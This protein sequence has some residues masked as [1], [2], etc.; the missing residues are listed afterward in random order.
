MIKY[1]TNLKFNKEGVII[2]FKKREISVL[3]LLLCVVCSCIVLDNNACAEEKIFKFRL[4][5][6]LPASSLNHKAAEHFAELVANKTNNRVEIEIYP[7]SQL[8]SEKD[9]ADAVAM[10]VLDFALLGMGEIDKRYKPT[11]VIDGPFVFRDREHQVKFFNSNLYKQ[12]CDEMAETINIRPISSFY[13]GTRY[14]TCNTIIKNPDDLKGKKIRCPDQPIFMATVRAMGAAPTPMAISEVYLAL[15]Q[16]VVDGQENPYSMIITMNFYEVQKYVMTTGHITSGNYI[17]TNEK[18]LN[19]LPSD[20]RNSILEAGL[21]TED[22]KNERAF[23]EEDNILNEIVNKG[24]QVIEVDRE[25][26][27]KAAQPVYD[28]YEKVWGEGLLEEIRA[29]K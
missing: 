23:E 13:F 24:M 22:W 3:V 17:F 8:G 12:M 2:V 29:I 26:F 15:Q 21:E 4:G 5:H 20:I 27:I 25:A 14:L 28:E 7:A 1:F 6:V 11:N 16:G 9:H 19:E 10:G 18:F